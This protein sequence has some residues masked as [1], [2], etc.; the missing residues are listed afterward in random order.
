MAQQEENSWSPVICSTLSHKQQQL[1]SL[2]QVVKCR[3]V[4]EENTA[5]LQVQKVEHVGENLAFS[6]YEE[7]VSRTQKNLKIEEGV[8]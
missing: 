8:Q 3:E 4:S 2:T 1:S 6:S 5:M 7:K